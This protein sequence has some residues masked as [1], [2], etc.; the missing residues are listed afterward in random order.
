[1]L[2]VILAL[3]VVVTAVVGLGYVPTVSARVPQLASFST[4]V[5]DV[6]GQA[7]Q[8]SREMMGQPP[9]P[10]KKRPAVVPATQKPVP[11]IER[12][13]PVPQKPVPRK[14]APKPPAGKSAAAKRPAQP[15]ARPRQVAPSRPLLEVGSSAPQFVLKDI[16]GV[17]Y[18]LSDF[19]GRR[20]AVLLVS[21]LDESGRAAIRAFLNRFSAHPGYS[22]II[23]ITN[24]DRVAVRRL[25]TSGI[26]V[27][28]LFGDE[29]F[30]ATYRL[31][32]GG[33]ALYVISERG[34]IA[35]ARLLGRQ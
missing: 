18:R 25:A 1:M 19:R 12:P 21:S 33:D 22:P 2:Y 28:I 32:R 26:H 24:P 9:A 30:Q 14:P 31:P 3:V 4:V 13:A 27:P 7:V 34:A 16:R 17:L 35:Q 6:V 15:P 8:W 23:I 5:E 10:P 20:V 11:V 29:E